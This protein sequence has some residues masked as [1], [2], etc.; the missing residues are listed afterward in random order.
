MD[1]KLKTIEVYDK[2][3]Q[4]YADKHSGRDLYHD[5]WLDFLSL[6][7]QNASLLEL[8]CGPGNVIRFFL[9]HRGD[10]KITGLDLAP[11]MI[12]YARELN[13]AAEFLV[14]DVHNLDSINGPYDAIVVSF[15]LPYLSFSD[16]DPFFRDLDRLVSE[17]GLLYLSF[18]EGEEEHS[19]FEKTSFSG[20]D[21][22]YIYYHRRDKV[23][24]LMAREGFK[25]EQFYT[26]IS[27]DPDGTTSTNLVYVA[28]R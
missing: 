11:K 15:C 4:N 22:I 8:G 13:P 23:E 28:K 19:G 1:K 20:D 25:I 9:D 27:P 21:E 10:L 16:L 12:E 14:Q 7:P 18:M 6:L 17:T 26:K 3:V 24:R 2:F 5:A